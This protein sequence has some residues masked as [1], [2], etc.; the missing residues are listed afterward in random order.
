MNWCKTEGWTTRSKDGRIVIRNSSTGTYT[1][2]V[3]GEMLKYR[4]YP[5]VFPRLR[6][7]K[8]YCEREFK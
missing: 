8:L 3:N 1:V 6:D 2:K 7:A 5:M 4:H